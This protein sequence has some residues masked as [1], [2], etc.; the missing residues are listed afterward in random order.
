VL[1]RS[2]L[3]FSASKCFIDRMYGA[4]ACREQAAAE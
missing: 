1:M 2:Y 3:V 4:V